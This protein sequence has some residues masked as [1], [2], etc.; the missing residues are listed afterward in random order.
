MTGSEE[1]GTL[2]AML[3]A[4]VLNSRSLHSFDVHVMRAGAQERRKAEA[5]RLVHVDRDI[6]CV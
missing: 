1:I 6:V 5:G 4:I 2:K 3:V